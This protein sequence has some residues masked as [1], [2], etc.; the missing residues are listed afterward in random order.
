[1]LPPFLF[2]RWIWVGAG[3]FGFFKAGAYYSSINLASELGIYQKGSTAC[4][5][6]FGS[7]H[8][9]LVDIGGSFN[10]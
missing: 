7:L 9:I 1:M 6:V 4:S 5:L 10:E 2:R 3:I 8:G